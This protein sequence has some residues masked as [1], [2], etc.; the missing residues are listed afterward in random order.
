MALPPDKRELPVED[1]WLRGPEWEIMERGAADMGEGREFWWDPVHGWVAHRGPIV[2][3][4]IPPNH[5][6]PY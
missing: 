4:S 1:I 6:K 3:V 5:L 2:Q